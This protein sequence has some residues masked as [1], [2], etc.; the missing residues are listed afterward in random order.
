MAWGNRRI[1]VEGQAALRRVRQVEEAAQQ[2]MS[3]KP[4]HTLLVRRNALQRTRRAGHM[5]ANDRETGCQCPS[6]DAVRIAVA[7]EYDVDL[8]GFTAKILKER[9][10]LVVA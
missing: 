8:K 1:D 9:Q 7:G 2:E 10:N 4:G 5:A 3:A 6:I